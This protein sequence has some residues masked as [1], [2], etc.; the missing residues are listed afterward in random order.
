MWYGQ[1]TNWQIIIGNISKDLL[2]I[3]KSRIFVGIFTLDDTEL[4]D[5]NVQHKNAT[6]RVPFVHRENISQMTDNMK[7][8][9]F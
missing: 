8:S 5:S 4:S 2:S 1:T 9:T 7:H 6:C 3:K